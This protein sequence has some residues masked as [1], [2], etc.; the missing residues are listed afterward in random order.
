MEY[1]A[2]VVD[3]VLPELLQSMGGILIEGPRACGKT[4][5]GLQHAASSV[6]LDASPRL[7]ELASLNPDSLLTGNTPRLIDEWQLAPTL[8]NAVRHAI[9]QRQRVGQF[10]LSGSAT[11]ADDLTRHSGAGRFLRLRMRPMALAETGRGSA[12]VSLARLVDGEPP[13]PGSSPLSYRDLAVEAVRGGWPALVGTSEKVAVR[14]NR[15]YCDD[16]TR[17]A[18]TEA[19]GVRHDP[20]RFRRLLGAIARNL[21]GES[22]LSTLIADVA[23][24]GTG[25]DPKTAG[26]YLDALS[27]VF[28]VE[29]LPAWSTALRS[30][31]RLR[32]T[33][34]LHLADPALACALLGAGSTRLAAD[35]EYFGQV[36]ESM[37]IRDLHVYAG[38]DARLFHYRDNTGLEVDCIIEFPDGRWAALEI[39]LGDHRVPEAERSLLRL[40]DDRIDVTRVG[41]PAFLAAITGGE[42]AYTLPSG[43]HVVP[44]AMLTA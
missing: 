4:S 27:R 8:W 42:Y 12:A 22:R 39:K 35:P 23:A 30:R 32:T 41:P 14:F 29:F 40:R 2:R 17:T 26:S 16:L 31:S 43:V 25:L 10:I 36:F 7:V 3:Q 21:S 11:P 9:D 1:L 34:K 18:V 13:A 5:T 28:A 24:G 44:L 15:A 6:R 19:T 20:V 33:A 38:H 37:A